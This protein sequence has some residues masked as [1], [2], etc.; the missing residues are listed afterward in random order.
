MRISANIGA[1]KNTPKDCIPKKPLKLRVLKDAKSTGTLLFSFAIDASKS[2][3]NSKDHEATETLLFSFAIDASKSVANSKD[4]EATG[5]LLF[6][7]AIDA[8]K[9]A[10]DS[11]DHETHTKTTHALRYRSIKKR[12]SHRQI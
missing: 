2:A 10:A 1:M 5:T 6:S 11:K 9:S 12:R 7:F 8:S 4:H 3:A